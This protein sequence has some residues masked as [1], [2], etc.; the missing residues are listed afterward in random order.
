MGD[1]AQQIQGHEKRARGE[2]LAALY[3]GL[4]EFFKENSNFCG[5]QM[6]GWCVSAKSCLSTKISN[7]ALEGIIHSAE[8]RV[9]VEALGYGCGSA[10]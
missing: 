5:S 2:P 9:L 10:S 8:T 7:G 1:A 6:D 3:R 4:L